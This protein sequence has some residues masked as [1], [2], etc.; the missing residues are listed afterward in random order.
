M[1]CCIRLGST[2]CTIPLTWLFHDWQYIVVSGLAEHCVRYQKYCWNRPDSTLLY[3]A[4]QYIM[5]DTMN[6]YQALQY[7]VTSGLAARYVQ[8]HKHGCIRPSS[9]LVYQAWQYII[10]DAISIVV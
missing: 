9:T 1:H 3:Q 10:Y 2:L 7:I 5:H 4:W 6:L 8:N